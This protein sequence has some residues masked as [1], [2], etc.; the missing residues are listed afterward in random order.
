MPV[1]VSMREMLEAGVHF[2]HLTRFRDPSMVPYIYGVQNQVHIINLEKTR[3]LLREALKFV[4][5]VAARNGKILFVGT[6]RSAQKLIAEYATQCGMPYV[7]HRWLGGTLTNYKT[8]KQ[9]IRRM[10][11]LEA[12][13][14]EG[15]LQHLTKKEGLTLMRELTK[16]TCS[17]GGIK[18]MGGLPDAVFIVD[19]GHEQIAVR[20]AKRLG[21]PVLG[22]VDTNSNPKGVDYPI[23]GN[24]DAMRAIEYY[25]KSVADTILQAK[26]AERGVVAAKYQEEFIE[27]DKEGSSEQQ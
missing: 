24:D 26:S 27:L 18:E 25:V 1:N 12:M 14:D 10:R 11:E 23:P 16:L 22:V 20:E 8:I 9:S 7:D 5:K 6:K 15:T 17:F 3:D 21:I 19:V 2:G 13:R 4:H